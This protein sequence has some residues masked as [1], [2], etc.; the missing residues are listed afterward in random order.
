MWER[1]CEDVKWME[2]AKNRVY[3]RASNLET[4][5]FRD[6]FRL[7]SNRPTDCNCDVP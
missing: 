2:L 3:W 6:L 1:M 4:S 7:L 5:V